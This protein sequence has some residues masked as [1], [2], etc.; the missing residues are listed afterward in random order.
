MPNRRSRAARRRIMPCIG[1]HQRDDGGDVAG[2]AAGEPLGHGVPV[3][4]VEHRGRD[5]LQQQQRRDDDHDRASQERARQDAPQP[6]HAACRWRGRGP[7][8]V[9]GSGSARKRLCVSAVQIRFNPAAA[10]SRGRGRSGGSGG[11]AGR[12]RSCGAGAS[13]ARRPCGC[14]RRDRRCWPRASRESAWPGVAASAANS[15]ASP[16]VRRISWPP[17]R[18]VRRSRSKLKAPK[19][20]SRRSADASGGTRRRMVRMRRTS[21]RG[22]NGL[23][24]IV[25]G[26]GLEAGDAVLRLAHGG[27]QQDRHAV[28]LRGAS[29]S[30]RGRSRRAS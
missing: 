4:L 8:R 25:V 13:S 21:S 15:S 10:C 9:T 26:A 11:S 5:D 23:A 2:D 20:S 7:W 14:R 24:Q 1:R 29:A 30:A 3:A 18:S 6:D 12:P 17:R 22:S 27:Q 16:P 28:L 19:R